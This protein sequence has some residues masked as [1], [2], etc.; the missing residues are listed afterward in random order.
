[1]KK[2]IS[3]FLGLVATA[4]MQTVD[5]EKKFADIWNA[6]SEQYG[7]S[8]FDK[9]VEA[10]LVAGKSV[11]EIIEHVV[12]RSESAGLSFELVYNK[13][14]LFFSYSVHEQNKVYLATARIKLDSAMKAISFASNL[15]VSDVD[16]SNDL[17]KVIIDELR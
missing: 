11:G 9:S 15:K 16:D 2:F 1:M 4:W 5:C 6:S 13:K 17:R 7:S 8:R 3:A 14:N 10:E 12:R